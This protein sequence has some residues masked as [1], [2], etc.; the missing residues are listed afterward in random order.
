M[1][2]SLES[3]KKYAHANDYSLIEAVKF[4]DNPPLSKKSKDLLDLLI[5]QI[6]HAR[7]ELE[8][9]QRDLGGVLQEYIISTGLID[10]FKEEKDEEKREE[11]L[12]NVQTLFDDI[13][14]FVS[15]NPQSN[16]ADYL[17]NTALMSAQD[18]VTNQEKVT[19]MTVHMAKGLEYEYVFV[20]GL[21]QGVFPNQRAVDE[22][23]KESPRRGKTFVLCS[24][25]KSKK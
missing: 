18:E 15:K 2:T 13:D 9:E 16:F 6:E 3:L 7:K 22:G 8:G 14:D 10:F 12:D 4:G 1:S 24:P 11:L 19:L 17:E 20:A 23:G 21:N 25:H 5:A